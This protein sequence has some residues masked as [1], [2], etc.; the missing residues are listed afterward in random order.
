MSILLA[1]SGEVQATHYTTYDYSRYVPPI[2]WYEAGRD[3][4]AGDALITS[5]QNKVFQ[6]G[7]MIFTSPP[8]NPSTQE[9]AQMDFHFK[10]VNAKYKKEPLGDVSLVKIY[11]R[12]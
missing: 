4:I 8:S 7:P 1:N 12:K 11:D 9:E 5:S 6:F 10:F 2:L 3:Y